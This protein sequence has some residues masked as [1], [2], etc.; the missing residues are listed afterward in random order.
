MRL[1]QAKLLNASSF[2]SNSNHSGNISGKSSAARILAQI[3]CLAAALGWSA[4]AAQQAPQPDVSSTPSQSTQIP[5]PARGTTPQEPFSLEFL[6]WFTNSQPDLRGG[7]A[8]TYLTSPTGLDFPGHGHRPLGGVLSIP[9]GAGNSLRFSYLEATGAGNTN[10]ATDLYLFTTN[11]SLADYLA[12]SYKLRNFKISYD[13]LSYPTPLNES[14]FRFRTLWEVQ[15]TTIQS[16]I[17]APFRPISVDSSGDPI[18][19]S[20]AGTRWLILPTFGVALDK[21]LSRHFRVEGKASGFGI[22]HRADTW[23]ADASANYE[24][25]HL[26]FIGAYKGFHFKTSPQSDQYLAQTLHG[27][28]IGVRWNWKP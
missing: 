15:Y 17:D 5:V 4:L 27:T 2:F 3:I 13:F 24:I 10:A 9:A 6:Y 20:A 7:A 28:Y 18:S 8:N 25:G 22:P 14:S 21:R 23:D 26:D 11:F 16:T 12:T 19:N 1:V